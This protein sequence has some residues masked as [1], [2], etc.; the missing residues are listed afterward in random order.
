LKK[1]ESLYCLLSQEVEE[2][3]GIIAKKELY[4]P[5]GSS[6][7]VPFISTDDGFLDDFRKEAQQIANKNKTKVKL[8]KFTVRKEM[9][10][11]DGRKLN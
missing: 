4:P 6:V 3:E 2:G 10:E 8:V 9:E 5:S 1:I 7:W 11:W